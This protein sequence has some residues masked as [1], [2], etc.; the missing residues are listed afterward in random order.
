LIYK[1]HFP[2]LLVHDFTESAYRQT[3][4]TYFKGP[5]IDHNQLVKVARQYFS[6]TDGIEKYHEIYSE[7]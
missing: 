7:L 3:L 6:L 5:A 4:N 1:Q 2:D